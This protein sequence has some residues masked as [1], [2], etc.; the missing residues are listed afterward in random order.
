MHMMALVALPPGYD[1]DV[2][3]AVAKILAPYDEA[4]QIEPVMEDGETYWTNPRSFWDWWQIGGRWTGALSDYNPAADPANV[5]ICDLCSG[6]GSR[7]DGA[8]F[9]A[10]WMESTGGCN[11]C[12]GKG[13]RTK[14]PTAWARYDGDVARWGDVRERVLVHG[15]GLPY[16]AVVGEAVAHRQRYDP[17]QPH[18]E[19]FVQ[20]DE[21]RPLLESLSDDAIVVVVVDYHS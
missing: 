5:E 17:N 4:L 11:G 13:T 16:T 20:T 19:R 14:W 18:G 1:G 7:P 8:R 9:G 21:V 15:D 6:T 2:E 12:G 3:E 10:E